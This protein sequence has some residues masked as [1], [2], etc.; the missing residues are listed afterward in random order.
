[1][2]DSVCDVKLLKKTMEKNQEIIKAADK[3][4]EKWADKIMNSKYPKDG[5][6]FY[7]RIAGFI[8]QRFWCYGKT[9]DYSDKLK[10]NHNCTGC[11]LCVRYVRWKTL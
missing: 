1:M 8:C 10:I 5:L 11:G 6:Y 9:K 4:I 3:K 7:D 2:P